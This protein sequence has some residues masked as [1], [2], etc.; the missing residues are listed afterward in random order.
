MDTA[1]AGGVE[2]EKEGVHQVVPLA[3]NAVSKSRTWSC[4]ERKVTTQ[5]TEGGPGLPPWPHRN[6]AQGSGSDRCESRT[7]CIWV[8]ALPLTW[9]AFRTP[10]EVLTK[11]RHSR[12]GAW[13]D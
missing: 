7:I 13:E 2:R 9:G 6:S 11:S 3:A 1:V 4:F 8:L 12:R 5:S 10:C